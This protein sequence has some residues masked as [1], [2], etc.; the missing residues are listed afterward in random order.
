MGNLHIFQIVYSNTEW[1]VIFL[2]LFYTFINHTVPR[3]KTSTSYINHI[4]GCRFLDYL[5]VLIIY[6]FIIY[7]SLD[8]QYL[9]AHSYS[10]NILYIAT[11]IIWNIRKII[12]SVKIVYNLLHS[13]RI[14]VAQVQ[15]LKTVYYTRGSV[16][17]MLWDC[18]PA[19][20]VI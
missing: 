14:F 11:F 2:I 19:M 20:V 12:T 4:D 8:F 1:K 6:F 17:L 9:E 13:C 16:M 10:L 3:P 15:N 7:I 5:N 18:M